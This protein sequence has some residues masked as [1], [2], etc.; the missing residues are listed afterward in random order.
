MIMLLLWNLIWWD[1]IIKK[2]K[3]YKNEKNEILSSKHE[4]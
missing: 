2:I 3:N 1:I 4:F